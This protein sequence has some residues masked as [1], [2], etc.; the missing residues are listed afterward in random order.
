MNPAETTDSDASQ[1]EFMHRK[2]FSEK[3]VIFFKRKGAA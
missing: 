1:A 3:K 2:R